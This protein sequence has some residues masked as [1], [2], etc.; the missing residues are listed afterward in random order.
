M[1]NAETSAYQNLIIHDA[2][3]YAEALT[4]H[5]S[6]EGCTIKLDYSHIACLQ[7]DKQAA[8][9][10]LSAASNAIIQLYNAGIITDNE[11]RSEISNYI[12]INPT[13]LD[14]KLKENGTN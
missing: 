9:T 10:A 7:D 2:E 3:S 11:S 14:G 4:N 8:S 5:I 6:P 12:D 13:I 1:S